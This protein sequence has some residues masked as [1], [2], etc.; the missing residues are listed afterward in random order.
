MLQLR[1]R[2]AGETSIGIVVGDDIRVA[3]IKVW[4]LHR[5][6]STWRSKSALFHSSSRSISVE[7]R[8][9]QRRRTLYKNKI[10]RREAPVESVDKNDIS[11]IYCI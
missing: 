11:I 1:N 10:K 2:V 4:R 8:N 9:I 3:I 7:G 6:S 5:N